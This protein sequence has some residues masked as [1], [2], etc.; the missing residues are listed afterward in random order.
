M[1]KTCILFEKVNAVNDMLTIVSHSVTETAW[2]VDL[3]SPRLAATMLKY[4]SGEISRS[5]HM[6]N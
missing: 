4:A 1:K 3:P 2:V 5:G 6:L